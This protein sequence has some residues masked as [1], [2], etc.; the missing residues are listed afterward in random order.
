MSYLKTSLLW[1]L[2]SSLWAWLSGAYAASA[3]GRL[4]N[5]FYRWLDGKWRGSFFVHLFYDEGRVSAAWPDSLLRRGADWVLNLPLRL[6]QAVYRLLRRP[7]DGSFFATLAFEAGKEAFLAAGWCMALILCIP[8][9]LW[10]NGYSVLLFA[11]VLVLILLGGM[12]D[13]AMRLSVRGFGPYL[14]FFFFAAVVSVPLSNYPGLSGRY[15]LYYFAC[16]LV[17]LVLVNAVGSSAQLLRLAGGFAL[18][19]FAASCYGLYQWLVIGVEVNPTFVDTN[20]NADMPGRVYS[21]FENPNAFGELLMMGLPIVVALIFVSRRWYWKAAACAVFC[22]G[23]VCLAV[24][25]SRASYVGLAVTAFVYVFFWNRK[26]IPLG[27]AVGLAAIPLLP[28]SVLNRILTITN[29]T[30][31]SISSRVPQYEAVIHLLRHEPITGAGLGADAVREA[32]SI[33]AF[34]QGTSPF[35]HAHNT[36]L[37]VWAETGLVGIASFAASLL[38]TVKSTARAVKESSDQIARHIAIGGTSALLGAMVCGLADYLWTYPRIMFVFWFIFGL[39]LS[40]I[41]LCR[42][43]QERA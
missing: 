28:D 25:Y 31:T 13:C 4:L 16:F 38:W 34:Y 24:T 2:L 7:L 33:Q 43:E 21:Y 3:L 27:I 9:S 35:V 10:S 11:L 37:Q 41:K 1:H 18:G 12:N 22:A 29:T 30:D 20:V 36:L 17:V 40:A 5:R 39:T 19:L 23:A 15:L 26:L 8:A 14:L 6:L 42:R 32:V